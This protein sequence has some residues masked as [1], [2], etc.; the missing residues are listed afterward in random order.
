MNSLAEYYDADVSEPFLRLSI[1]YNPFMMNEIAV[2]ELIFDPAK[3]LA[4]YLKGLPEE[5]EWIV[6]YDGKAIEKEEWASITP[7]EYST[8]S[9][10]RVPEGGHGAKGILRI[11]AML[12]VIAIAAFVAPYLAGALAGAMGGVSAGVMAGMIAGIT[13]AITMVGALIINALLP[14]TSNKP[15]SPSYGDDGPKNTAKEGL[16]I[17]KVYGKFRVGGQIT[18]LFSKNLGTTRTIDNVQV[19]ASQYMFCRAVLNDGP[20][21]NIQDIEINGNPITTFNDVEFRVYHGDNPATPNDWF[22]EAIRLININ[23]KIFVAPIIY[24][25]DGPVDRLRADIVFPGGL[26]FAKSDGSRV[27]QTVTFVLKYQPIDSLGNPTGPLQP[28]PLSTGT[29]LTNGTS[30]TDG[31]TNVWTTDPNATGATFQFQ[32]GDMGINTGRYSSY[33]EYRK[34]GDINWS[35]GPIYQGGQSQSYTGANPT[36]LTWP[37][38]NINMSFTEAGLYEV[39]APTAVIGDIL[40]DSYIPYSNTVAIATT[41]LTVTDTTTVA[42]RITYESGRLPNSRYS[43]QISRTV[44]SEVG[45]KSYTEAWLSDVGEINVQNVNLNGI[46]HIDVKIRVDNQL[47][48]VPSITA[49]VTGSTMTVYD[50]QGNATPNTYS[51]NPADIVID[52]LTNNIQGDAYDASKIIYPS[53]ADFRDFCTANSFFFNGVFDQVQTVWD[54]VQQVAKVGR[55]M[56]VPKGTRFAAI[57]D[58][59]ANPVQMFG[60]GNIV[61]DSFQKTWVSLNDRANEI[62]VTFADANNLYQVK[63]LRTTDDQ[64]LAQGDRLKTTNIDGFGM[65]NLDQVRAFADYSAKQNAY[66]TDF[67]TFDAPLESISMDLGDVALIQHDSIDFTE[68]V[69]GR[70]AA[71]STTTVIKLDRPAT[72]TAG[73]T[74]SL[75]VIH[76]TIQRYSGTIASITSNKL[77]VTG[78]PAA[79]LNN[80]TRLQQGGY[81]IDV[82]RVTAGPNGSYYISVDDASHLTTGA[83]TLWDTDVIEEQTVVFSAGTSETVTVAAPFSWAP[84]QY[85]NF[86]FGQVATVQLPY[87]LRN[88]SGDGVHRRTLGF[89]RYDAN[90]YLPGDWSTIVIENSGITFN[91]AQVTALSADYDP[92]PLPTQETIPVL[93][94]WL[95]PGVGSYGG[96]DVWAS[97]DDG[98]TFQF[99]QTV[100]NVTQLQWHFQRNQ[101]LIFRV[102]AFDLF[103][104]RAR[105]ADAPTTEVALAPSD[106]RIDPPTNLA[107]T[108]PYWR[109]DAA[110]TVTWSTPADG[111]AL[112]YEV[113][114]QA[115]N[116]TD[117]AALQ[118]WCGY[119]IGITTTQNTAP[120]SP[121]VGDIWVDDTTSPSTVTKWSGSAW[122]GLPT[123]VLA[124][125]SY[126]ANAQM[127]VDFD[128]IPR[129]V[130]ADYVVRV[131]SVRGYARS[132]WSYLPMQIA[133]PTMPANIT[134]LKCENGTADAA[135]STFAS[136]DVHFTWTD[137]MASLSGTTDQYGAPFYFQD[138]QVNILTPGGTL[139]RTEYVTSPA[140]VYTFNKN[141]QDNGGT[142][143]KSFVITVYFRGKQGQLSA[144]HS[145]TCTAVSPPTPVNVITTLAGGGFTLA[146]PPCPPPGC[147][148]ILIWTSLTS[149]IN[150][151]TQTPSFDGGPG[152]S[153]YVVATANQLVYYRAAYYGWYDKTPADLNIIA[154]ESIT[155]AG[156]L[157]SQIGGL[158]PWGLVNVTPG[159]TAP[160]SPAAGDIWLDSSGESYAMRRWDGGFWQPFSRTATSQLVDDANLGGTAGWTGVSSIPAGVTGAATGFNGSGILQT[161]I[162]TS[163][164]NA[165]SLLRYASGGL[166]NGELTADTT[167]NHV[168]ASITGQQAWATAKISV[169]TTA[170]S[171]PATGDIWI[172]TTTTPSVFNRWNGTAWISSTVTNT[173]QIIDGANL[174]GTAAW[175]G[176][177]SIPG[178]VTG[179]ATGFNSSGILQTNIPSA[180]ANTSN[181][182]RYASGGLFSGELTADTT[183]NHISASITGQQAWAT[184]KVSVATTAPS[185]PATGD[186]W[187]N[188]TTTPS[189]FNRWNGSAWSASTV[190]NTNQITDGANLGGTAAWTGVTSR[191]ANL[192]ALGGTEP[193][194]NALV[195]MGANMLTDSEF[196]RAPSGTGATN[197]VLFW[198]HVGN[199]NTGLA[200][201]WGVNYND[202]SAYYNNN[203]R[204]FFAFANGTPAAG[205][206]FQVRPTTMLGAVIAPFACQPGDR[207][208]F[209]MQIATY[210]SGVSAGVDWAAYDGTSA[211]GGGTF[212]TA[213]TDMNTGAVNW[214]SF[215]TISGFLTVPADG[216]LSKNVR[217]FSLWISC[218]ADAS[219]TANPF[220]FMAQPMLCKVPSG[221]T[222]VTPYSPGHGDPAAMVDPSSNQFLGTGSVPPTV[223]GGAFSYTCNTSSVTISWSAMTL[224]RIDGTTISVTSGSLTI[225]SLSSGTS[226]KIYPYCVDTGGTSSTV[227]FATGASGGTGSPAAAYSYNPP[228]TY[229][230]APAAAVS[231]ARGVIN[232][233][234]FIVSTTTSG[235]GGGGGGGSSCMHPSTLMM[236]EDGFVCADDLQVGDLISSPSGFVAI[237]AIQREEK[238][239]WIAVQVDGYFSQ[240]VTPEHLFYKPGMNPVAACDLRLG[241]LLMSAGDHVEVTGLIYDDEPADLVAISVDDPHLIHVGIPNLI[242]HN[243]PKL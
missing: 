113:S 182:L 52:I 176:V 53:F 171:S 77:N 240:R 145:M 107:F 85:A 35:D 149:G 79:P 95:S 204:V 156:L 225:S 91:V 214:A 3:T 58:A 15:E 45:T 103:G 208:F 89:T 134:G 168:S 196:I 12:A 231:Y 202:G 20:V 205:S 126:S 235:T 166:F 2:E 11:V 22:D 117:Y 49:L 102:V 144:S 81:D 223:P 237:K 38:I 124:E 109:V 184:A 37:L 69:S 130:A 229:G 21:S 154:E 153:F 198:N 163:L 185:S 230:S 9:L 159:T 151:I 33:L 41:Q 17:P 39:R 108:V 70:L 82:Y 13:G 16:P 232:L 137:I 120:T 133:V 61:K 157:A 131:R 234:S 136:Q 199:N 212:A 233:N 65:T 135:S 238:S 64:A 158:G 192:S 139:L 165:S 6:G 122:V 141:T 160:G 96:A 115:L 129:L 67:I 195:P 36:E 30:P 26:Y 224:Y 100:Q 203:Q 119:G 7:E 177:S 110:A 227:S 138:Y 94:S 86:M 179:A 28:L 114:W 76:D 216:N 24:E 209:S 106:V 174:G 63:T 239:L 132:L 62:Q 19:P 121:S 84:A 56:V 148:G 57:Y 186:I 187:I 140:Y 40:S 123:N 46:A 72:M 116:S 98:V 201:S 105:V 68:G 222:A 236:V 150:P 42:K 88:I 101:A 183:I 29:P 193:I 207:F 194:Q 118:T 54:C 218:G 25:T 23:Q 242:S 4:D 78:L 146:L 83:I 167:I 34:F 50:D 1:V 74:Y 206:F 80:I 92:N 161:D 59:P 188:T 143:I 14:G 10:V 221:Q 181:L 210:R 226:Y 217:G 27:S 213:T 55:G 173:N 87:R 172:N 190:T 189:V 8:I 71:G 191:P 43:I 90:A 44:N 104:N 32:T 219:Q 228:T 175:A 128:V 97:L 243:S 147:A 162:P 73:N 111:L 211:G 31:A 93:I 60:P 66:I 142:P 125:S 75:L 200:L 48:S 99:L 164:A 127:T 178:G 51:N 169:A 170:P 197:N 155:V 215:Q 5:V 152:N 18:D 241:D 180:L 47:S 112:A 220:F